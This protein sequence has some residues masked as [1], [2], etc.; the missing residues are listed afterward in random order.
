MAHLHANELLRIAHVGRGEH[1]LSREAEDG[2]VAAGAERDGADRGDEQHWLAEQSAER[3]A[4]IAREVLDDGDAARVACVLR[5][6]LDA[7]ERAQRRQARCLG[8]HAVGDVLLDLLLDVRAELAI[9]LVIEALRGERATGYEGGSRRASAATSSWA[10]GVAEGEPDRG[11]Q[12]LPLRDLVLE[13]RASGARQRVELRVASG[14]VLAHSAR[15][16]PWFSSRW[17]AG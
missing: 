17:S 14:L 16:S 9:E 10:L 6:L 7:A 11:R 1:E 8:R 13:L 2:D 12:A 4:E 5:H 3:V 15:I